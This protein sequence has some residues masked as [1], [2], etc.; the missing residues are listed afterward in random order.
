MRLAPPLRQKPYALGEIQNKSTVAQWVF[1]QNCIVVYSV[2]EMIMFNI[3]Q[4]KCVWE[5]AQNKSRKFL[6]AAAAIPFE[7]N[8]QKYHFHFI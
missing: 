6:A 3:S 8:Q 1:K 5:K 4:M 2:Y 7:L